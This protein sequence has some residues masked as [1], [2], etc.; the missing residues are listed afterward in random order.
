[1]HEALYFSKKLSIMKALHPFTII[2]AVLLC[3]SFT[4]FTN[5]NQ[6]AATKAA[7]EIPTMEGAWKLISQN[8]QAVSDEIIRL[9][10]S[11]YFATTH[12][13]GEDN[14]FVSAHGGWYRFEG[15]EYIQEMSFFTEDSTRVGKEFR[16]SF[17]VDGSKVR[18]DGVD[19]TEIWERISDRKDELTGTW[20]MLGRQNENGELSNRRPVAARI[21][22][23][24]LAGG[25]FQWAAINTETGEFFGTG[26]GTY[27]AENGAYVENITVFSRDNSRVGARLPFSFSLKDGDWYHNGLTSTGGPMAE[28]WGLYN[29]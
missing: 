23:K 5:S 9:Y 3:I 29:Q 12:A 20:R 24:V 6:E 27:T 26:G 15:D 16:F 11:E 8:D 17:L 4:A 13:A 22:V 14:A 1:M 2:L 21:T 19:G 25:R 18:F 7:T 28:V 10:T